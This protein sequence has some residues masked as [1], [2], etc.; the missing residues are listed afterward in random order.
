MPTL[1]LSGPG[2]N[3]LAR[4][5]ISLS[6]VGSLAAYPPAYLVDGRPGR[7]WWA[8]APGSP[9]WTLDGNEVQNGGF[10]SW[11]GGAPTSWTVV[12]AGG[13]TV[14]QTTTPG[15][16]DAG[17]SAV[18]FTP[19]AGSA[20]VRQDLVVRAGE[21]RS[22]LVRLLNGTGTAKAR[23]R[24]LGRGYYLT[25]GGTWQA[26][27]TDFQ[28]GTGAYAGS[29]LAYN[30]PALAT[31][32]SGTVALRLE[33]YA[34]GGTGFADGVAHWMAQDFLSI[35]GHNW[36][37]S[38]A[39]QVESSDDGSI[40]SVETITA[41]GVWQPIAYYAAWARRNR[42]FWRYT[43]TDAVGETP[44]AAGEMVAG[45]ALTLA[46][47]PRWGS[48]LREDTTQGR[49]AGADG[50]EWVYTVGERPVRQLQVPFLH[51]SSL[52]EEWEELRDELRR[53]RHGA[54]SLVIVPSTAR[55]DVLFGRLAAGGWGAT[56]QPV[57]LEA[58][59]VV[60][61]ERPGPVYGL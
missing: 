54:D 17:A 23:L 45:Q 42:R 57:T 29:A 38:V 13:G 22:I 35:H 53:C 49:V 40:W 28:T 30:V 32:G 58:A 14:T 59:P 20:L 41:G 11:A 27:A 37:P 31:L 56:R 51:E 19:G 26:A 36:G 18:K 44:L 6:G 24:E 21:V 50:D 1:L 10:E 2:M 7:P 48:D 43:L 39:L 8:D 52:I 12:E 4:G 15:E 61:N 34:T 55:P 33:I 46:R 5:S 60:I 16:F 3:A 47:S 25:S 9:V